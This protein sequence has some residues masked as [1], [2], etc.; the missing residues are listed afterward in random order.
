MSRKIVQ[1]LISITMAT[2]TLAG[3][4][5]LISC[6][7]TSSQDS[8]EGGATISTTD[9]WLVKNG[10]SPYTIVVEENPSADLQ[11]AVSEMQYFFNLAT[12]ATLECIV[13]SQVSNLQG[14]YISLGDTKI[15][16]AAEIDTSFDRLGTDGYV[17]KTYGN[18][19]VLSGNTDVATNY[20]V[21]GYLKM[22]VGLEIYAKDVYTYNEERSVKL[23]DV[24]VVDIPDIAVRTGGTYLY[25]DPIGSKRY[26]M[27]IFGDMFALRGHSHFT[28]LP[29]AD[30]YE[31]HPEY[32]NLDLD[33][34]GMPTQLAWENEEMWDAFATAFKE[35]IKS[36]GDDIKYINLGL[37]DNWKPAYHDK[38]KYETIRAE[39][40]GSDSAMMVRFLKYVITDVNAWMAETYPGRYLQIAFFAYQQT[41]EPPA[42]WSNEKNDYVPV[43]EDLVMPDNVAVYIAPITAENVSHPYFD[44]VTNS[45]SSRTFDGW[46]TIAKNMIVWAYSTD[47]FNY[48][49]PF[50]SWG[51]IKENY[52]QYKERGVSYLFEQGMERYYVPNYMELRQYLVAKLSWDT[53]LDTETLIIDFMKAYYRDGWEDMYEYFSLMR[54]YLTALEAEGIYPAAAVASLEPTNTYYV[55]SNYFPKQFMDILEGLTD[56]ALEKVD[57]VGDSEAR[58]AIEKDRMPVRYMILTMYKDMYNSSDYLAM[59]EDFRVTAERCNF[60][61]ASE[62]EK[63]LGSVQGI[64]DS[65]IAG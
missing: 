2:F 64:I 35:Y 15:A 8:S 11:F 36:L 19:M 38:E 26:R 18:A 14:K 57:A 23:I 13:D 42:V 24:D 52:T 5:S 16:E 48:L 17:V 50:N 55:N 31:E 61:M 54:T 10:V 32:Y 22:Q 4:F 6:E 62:N 41:E 25:K 12:G 33:A 3:C 63:G 29:P 28:I 39:Y 58:F 9:T 59:V 44:P 60:T 65:W 30:Y 45:K 27:R 49:V 21:Y 7:K 53:T 46:R 40:G 47:F 43:S 20:A 1:K 34:S 56:K 37:E 51:S